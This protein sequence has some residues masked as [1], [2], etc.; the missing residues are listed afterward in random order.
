M[1][2]RA[3]F[4]VFLN[5]Q[6]PYF[7]VNSDNNVLT[8]LFQIFGSGNNIRTEQIQR[9]NVPQPV[10]GDRREPVGARLNMGAVV[11][12]GAFGGLVF[13]IAIITTI[14]ILVKR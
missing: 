5:T 13:L 12:L 6:I 3:G 11:A 4:I 7:Y 1:L 10:D 14:V 8:V 9:V 2:H